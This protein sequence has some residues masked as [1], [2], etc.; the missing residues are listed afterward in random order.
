M[1]PE[2]AYEQKNWTVIKFYLSIKIV[3]SN[4]RRSAGELEL[5]KSVAVFK[6]KKTSC[7]LPARGSN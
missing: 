3:M 7:V 6:K 2:L 4:T 1:N 5:R